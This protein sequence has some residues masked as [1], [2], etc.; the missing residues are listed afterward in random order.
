MSPTTFDTYKFIK[1]LK[2]AGMPEQQA[3]AVI[4]SI[5]ET[6]KVLDFVSKKDLGVLSRDM[7]EFE[8]RTII[9]IG[10]ITIN[11]IL[12]AATIIKLRG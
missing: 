4:E 7:K 6:R 9:K 10:Y 3:E 11:T 1:K 8:Q 12:I 5:K 2:A